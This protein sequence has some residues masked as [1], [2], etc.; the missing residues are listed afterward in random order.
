M[1]KILTLVG[2]LFALAANAQV[3][4]GTSTPADDAVLEV[5]SANKG[6]LIPRVVLTD[7][8]TKLTENDKHSGSLLVYNTATAGANDLAVTPG[9]YYWTNDVAEGS[10]T[11]TT[12][13]KWNRIINASDL[14]ILAS[15]YDITGTAVKT[16]NK[17]DGKFIYKVYLPAI[18]KARSAELKE[19]IDLEGA[20]KIHSINVLNNTTLHK[21]TSS[22]TDLTYGS[23]KLDFKIGTGN[24]YNILFATETPVKVLVEFTKA[25]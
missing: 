12:T 3:G 19:G 17:L 24:M 1:K 13:G 15:T 23:D 20:D 7:L 10:V 14:D 6:V 5:K 4:I 22:V 16:G 11:E 9:Y 21:L 25:N 18:L 2:L 8:S